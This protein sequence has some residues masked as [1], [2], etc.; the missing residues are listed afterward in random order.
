MKELMNAALP[1]DAVITVAFLE[2]WNFVLAAVFEEDAG[3]AVCSTV[4]TV[5]CVDSMKSR[6]GE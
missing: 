6:S 2:L 4:T 1:N 5:A 3:A